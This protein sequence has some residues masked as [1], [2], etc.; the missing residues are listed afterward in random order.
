[1]ELCSYA[2]NK[3]WKERDQRHQIRREKRAHKRRRNEGKCILIDLRFTYSVLKRLQV[4][5]WTVP[6]TLFEDKEM[7]EKREIEKS[8]CH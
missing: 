5:C 3:T 2:N 4:L 6:K 7:S 1:M 8:Y